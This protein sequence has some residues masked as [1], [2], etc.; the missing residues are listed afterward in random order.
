MDNT[1]QLRLEKDFSG[2]PWT[3]NLSREMKY[4]HPCPGDRENM[5]GDEWDLGS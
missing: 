3:W 5:D 2:E 1:E 4:D